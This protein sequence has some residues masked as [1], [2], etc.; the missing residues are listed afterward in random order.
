MQVPAA[1]QDKE[2]GQ[3]REY[4]QSMDRDASQREKELLQKVAELQEE[5]QSKVRIRAFEME[6][7]T[8]R[9]KIFV[10]PSILSCSYSLLIW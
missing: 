5:C 4:V 2:L 10:L 9:M 3:L 7:V 1:L 6:N 8:E